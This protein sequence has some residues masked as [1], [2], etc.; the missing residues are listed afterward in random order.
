M[1]KQDKTNCGFD[2]SSYAAQRLFLLTHN[3]EFQKDIEKVKEKHK[4]EVQDL[5]KLYSATSI[6]TKE[7][8]SSKLHKDIENICNAIPLYKSPL[9][10]PVRTLVAFLIFDIG[11]KPL[12]KSLDKNK[13][14]NTI[15]MKPLV[16]VKTQEGGGKMS[17][18]FSIFHNKQDLKEAI[19]LHWNE[20][21][22][23]KEKMKN[24]YSL[25]LKKFKAI[26]NFK[27]AW[28]IYKEKDEKTIFDIF[29]DRDKKNPSNISMIISRIQKKIDNLYQ[30]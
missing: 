10:Y 5:K 9:R 6:I 25:P 3:T 18:S 13:E 22:K 12:L 16:S 20:I 2:Y 30:K 28:E 11:I 26:A 23:Q 19:D 4:Q 24:K 1:T 29:L 27:E 14:I 21:K 15:I 17:I 7:K 8:G